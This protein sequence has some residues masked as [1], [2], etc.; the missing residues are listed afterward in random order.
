M[1]SYQLTF[2]ASFHRGLDQRF[3]RIGGGW[4]LYD[5]AFPGARS[6]TRLVDLPFALPTAVAGIALTAIYSSNGW[7]DAISNRWASKSPLRPGCPGRTDL[8]WIAVRG[9]RLFNRYSKIWTW[10][11]K[12]PPPR[13]E[14]IG[15]KP[16]GR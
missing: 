12:R 13:W 5:T 9:K 1:A 3:L 4:V 10:R 16:S 14:P 7:I 11:W 2:G 8:H 6:W 15:C